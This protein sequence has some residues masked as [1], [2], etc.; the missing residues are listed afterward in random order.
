M[1]IGKI[2]DPNA[3]NPYLYIYIYIY[4]LMLIVFL[5][6]LKRNIKSITQLTITLL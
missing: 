2:L 3:L 5:V 4:I 6:L 1:P